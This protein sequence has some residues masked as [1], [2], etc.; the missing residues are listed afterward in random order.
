MTDIIYMSFISKSIKKSKSRNQLWQESG[1]TLIELIIVIVIIGIL[2]SLALAIF[3]GQQKA[4]A[5]ATVQ[6]DVRSSVAA[7]IKENQILKLRTEDQFLARAT[8]SD[9]NTMGVKIDNA[10]TTPVACIWGLR[11]FSDTDIYV[12]HY[13]SDTAK[14]IE[15]PCS[16]DTASGLVGTGSDSPD[17]PAEQPTTNNPTTP[18]IPAGTVSNGGGSIKV[19]D[20]NLTPYTDGPVT[21][22]PRYQYNSFGA[23]SATIYVD[24]KS[25]SSTLVNW[26]YKVDLSKAPYWNATAA[27]ISYNDSQGIPSFAGNTFKVNNININNGVSSTRSITI[28]YNLTKFVPPNI[29][30]LYTVSITPQSGNSQW[31][32]CIEVRVTSNEISPITWS[33]DVDLSKYFKSINGKTPTF[34]NLKSVSQGNSIY[35]VTGNSTNSDTVSSEHPVYNDQKICYNPAGSPW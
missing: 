3:S 26:E 17:S 6:S 7:L 27:E 29:L 8:I 35:T 15:G 9:N 19:D 24:I 12:Y 25:T 16:G 33:A 18:T 1:F 13:S 30:E 10:A 31:Y 14:F 32:A 20:T 2:G 22:T 11:K 28:T 4:A 23:N 21:Y 34:Q 5:R